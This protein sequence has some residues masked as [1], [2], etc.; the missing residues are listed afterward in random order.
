MWEMFLMFLM[1]EFNVNMNVFIN[2]E[3]LSKWIVT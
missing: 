1:V 2:Y 3:K